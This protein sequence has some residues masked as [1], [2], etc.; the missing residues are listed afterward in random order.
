MKQYLV[1]YL[2]ILWDGLGFFGFDDAKLERIRR[3]P[4]G[5]FDKFK[6]FKRMILLILGLIV[7]IYVLVT[8]ILKWGM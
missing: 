2:F 5:W 1:T 3:K 7:L 4:A 6:S 8:Q